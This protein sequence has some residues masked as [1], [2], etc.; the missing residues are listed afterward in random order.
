MLWLAAIFVLSFVFYTLFRWG[1]D[2]SD[3][4]PLRADESVCLWIMAFIF[5]GAHTGLVFLLT[6]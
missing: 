5:A 3:P 1:C 6:L 2:R 4:T